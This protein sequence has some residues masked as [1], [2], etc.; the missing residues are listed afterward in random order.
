MQLTLFDLTRPMVEINKPIR[1]IELF[2]GYGSQ[3]MALRNIGVNF[4][5][6]RVVE[7]DKY[8]IASYNAVHGTNFPTIDVCD[9]KGVDMGIE[10]KEHFTYLLTYSF[11]CTDISLAGQQAGMSKGADTRSSLLWEVER[12]LNEL[13]ETESLPQILVME[14]VTAIHNE[15]NKPDFQK[16]LDFLNK[17]GYST[18]VQD[19]NAWDYGV[20]QSRDRTFAVSILG[21]YNYHFP[22]PIELKYCI[23]DYYEEL[24]E[25]Q[26]LQLVVKSPKAL[27]LLERLDD[28]G[29]LEE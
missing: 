15:K 2:A 1:L 7:F 5:T 28:E 13:K 26:A 20:A 18:Y 29:K 8:A 23:E 19:L 12:I 3:A 21:D 10:D 4:E 24:T 25:E 27:E 17:L 6:Y 16:W 11:P 22:E 14:N 9:V